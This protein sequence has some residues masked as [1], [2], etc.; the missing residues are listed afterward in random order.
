M[1]SLDE[2]LGCSNSSEFN[3]LSMRVFKFQYK[4][5][6][7]YKKFCDLFKKN[8]QNINT[9]KEIPFLPISFFKTHKIISSDK[10]ERTFYSSGIF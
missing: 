9:L 3:N 6:N 2:I 1:I 8:P 4:N 10:V 5:N 7:V